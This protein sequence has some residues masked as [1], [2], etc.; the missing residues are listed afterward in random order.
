[1]I[2]NENKEIASGVGVAAEKALDF[3]EKVIAGPI[4]QGTGIF[5]DKVKFWRFKN[6][7]DII[8]QARKYLVDRGIQTP[9]AI[10]IK[11]V[12]TLLEYSSFE[13][14]QEMQDNWAKLLANALDPSNTF[15]TCHLFSQILNQISVNEF[16]ILRHMF[17]R[18]FIMTDDHRPYLNRTELIR[19]SNVNYTTG[20]L[21][22]DNLLRLRLIEEQPPVIKDSS[23]QQFMRQR[24]EEVMEN[25]IVSSDNFRLSKFGTEFGIQTMK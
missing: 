23:R 20:M 15:N 2:E 4:I 18:S 6:Q 13:E 16:Y 12:T 3:I 7:V 24:S 21:L 8:L 11:D 22:I 10:P 5:T 17:S 25:E 9:K 19:H 14:N 1:M